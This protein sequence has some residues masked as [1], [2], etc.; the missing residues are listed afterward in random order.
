MLELLKRVMKWA[1]SADG[2]STTGYILLLNGAAV[3]FKSKKQKLIAMSSEETEFVAIAQALKQLRG[4]LKVVFELKLELTLLIPVYKDNQAEIRFMNDDKG[5]RRTKNI[6][7][8][9]MYAKKELA[10]GDIVLKYVYTNSNLAD[11]LTKGLVGAK[12]VNCKES[13]QM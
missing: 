11:G 3:V 4:Y 7:L 9:Y 1:S 2:R 13:L 12:I 5:F 6:E 8:Q 10:K